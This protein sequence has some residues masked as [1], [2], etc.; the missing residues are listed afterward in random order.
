[1]EW[2][3][4]S[5]IDRTIKELEEEKEIFQKLYKERKEI[6]ENIGSDFIELSPEIVRFK[7][8]I[9]RIEERI[10]CFNNKCNVQ[11]GINVVSYE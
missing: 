9:K 1:M 10:K 4:K 11:S 6:L 5:G 2:E 7:W 8:N 3:E